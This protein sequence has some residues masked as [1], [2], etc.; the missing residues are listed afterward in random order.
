MEKE[1]KDGIT[2]TNGKESLQRISG[3]KNLSGLCTDVII[4]EKN[5]TSTK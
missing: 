5:A 3:P 4:T 2:G 1:E